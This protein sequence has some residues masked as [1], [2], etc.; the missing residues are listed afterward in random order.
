[1]KLDRVN[2][3]SNDG[4]VRFTATNK[5]NKQLSDEDV[6]ALKDVRFNADFAFGID[7]GCGNMDIISP[8]SVLSVDWEG[9]EYKPVDVWGV[10]MHML[11]VERN[12]AGELAPAKEA[13]GSEKRYNN[14]I[15][16]WVLYDDD[17]SEVK[18]WDTWTGDNGWD[19]FRGEKQYNLGNKTIQTYK[20]D[21]LVI[22]TLDKPRIHG[23][24]EWGALSS[25][26]FVIDWGDGKLNY[27][28]ETSSEDYVIGGFDGKA[29]VSSSE[30]SDVLRENQ[31]R[32]VVIRSGNDVTFIFKAGTMNAV[33]GK[34]DYDFSVVVNRDYDTAAGLPSQ[35][36]S[37][38]FVAKVDYNY[39]GQLPAEAE[40]RVYVGT[41]YAGQTLYYSQLMNDGA[42]S[43]VQEA[44]A[45]AAGYITV[46]QNHCSSYVVTK[47]NPAAGSNSGTQTGG[48]GGSSG[49]KP[50]NGAKP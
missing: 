7:L 13:D 24:W 10:E 16:A 37:S 33:A 3:Q 5:V 9:S 41:G 38:N 25:H 22:Q 42:L 1:M 48:N 12:A 31:T 43:L 15:R 39:S 44:V 17:G 21:I 18:D 27:K 6:E 45:D 32:N 29:V 2:E 19:Y 20:P 34:T 35:V 46:K 47:T 14:Y 4:K 49:T 40:I 26:T 23:E 8:S 28:G 50:G 36:D 11:W 30:F